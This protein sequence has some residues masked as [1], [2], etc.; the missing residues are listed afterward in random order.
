MTVSFWITGSSVLEAQSVGRMIRLSQHVPQLQIERAKP[1]GRMAQETEIPLT[2]SLNLQNQDK[3]EELLGRL[4]DPKNPLYGKFLSSDEFAGNF[5]LPTQDVEA[6]KN[7]LLVQGLKVK[8]QIGNTIQI[9][10]SVQNIESAFGVQLDQY[11]VAETNGTQ[12]MHFAASQDPLLRSDIASKILSVHGLNNFSNRVSHAHILNSHA[13]IGTGPSGGLSPS[14]LQ[15]AYSLPT[16]SASGQTLALM[17]LDGYLASDIQMY[18]TNFGLKVPPITN[19]LI[20]GVSGA[21]GA[22]AIEVALDIELMIA[23]APSVSKILVYEGQNSDSGIIDLYSRIATDNQAKQVST[24]WGGP[25]AQMPVT[26]LNSE[27]LIFKQMAAQGQSIYAAAG[28]NGAF[29]DGTNLGVD[30]PASQPYVTGAGGTTLSLSSGAYKFESSWSSAASGSTAASGG[31]GG[32]SGIWPIPSWQ[33]GLA[34]TANKGSQTLRMVPDL[35]A[36]A[37][38][39]TG[40]SFVVNGSFGVVG[41][42]SCVAPIFAAVTAI[43]NSA[44][45]GSGLATL[46]YMNPILY[47]LGQSS[48]SSMAFIDIAD[49]STNLFYPATTGYDLTTGLGSPN[50]LLF[51]ELINPIL[52]PSPPGGLATASH[53]TVVSLNWSAATDAQ[54]YNIYRAPSSTGPFSVVASNVSVLNFAD[55][56]L[57]NGTPYYY[58]V[59]A[60]DSSGQSGRTAITQGMPISA[61][62]QAPTGVGLAPVTVP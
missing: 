28:D 57:T 41:G 36:N 45:A 5:Y 18:A 21:A 56:G 34:T 15:K 53:N 16:T 30:D 27:N 49:S 31:G 25:E 3:L 54:S 4:Y 20:D 40:Y 32:I 7:Y 52:P 50:K 19:V 10:G 48:L 17:E 11:I 44:R 37:N 38:P 46:G 13:G 12:N 43:L 23:V 2:I 22:G 9:S 60:V 42:T 14:D 61:A 35:S 8:G 62:P 47:R 55:V 39:S 6:V 59:V 51:S 24:S 33:V 58:Y 1:A 29:D 26:V